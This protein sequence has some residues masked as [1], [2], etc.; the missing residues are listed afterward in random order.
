M[1]LHF[2]MHI[3]HNV[4]FNKMFGIYSKCWRLTQPTDALVNNI[5]LF[6][7]KPIVQFIYYKKYSMRYLC[8]I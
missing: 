8:K 4:I 6:V 7:T 3:Q 5:K 1:L 2:I